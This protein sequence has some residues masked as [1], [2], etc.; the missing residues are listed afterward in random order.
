ME[1]FFNQLNGIDIDTQF[2]IKERSKEKF[3]LEIE[4]ITIENVNHKN[5]DLVFSLPSNENAMLWLSDK[6]E[7]VKHNDLNNPIGKRITKLNCKSI[8]GGFKIS[9][10]GNHSLGFVRWTFAFDKITLK[11]TNANT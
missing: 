9:F 6:E 10:G 4:T 11:K 2:Q 8:T 3:V 1:V 7:W 5:V